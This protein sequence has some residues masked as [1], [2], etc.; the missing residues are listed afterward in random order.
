MPARLR[1]RRA[2]GGD[3]GDRPWQRPVL[4]FHLEEGGAAVLAVDVQGGDQWLTTDDRIRGHG[5]IRCPLGLSMPCRWSGHD[6]SSLSS[7]HCTAH[8]TVA[9]S[10]AWAASFWRRPSASATTG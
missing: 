5:R 2:M 1:P 4:G 7:S 3:R 8:R 6:P 10:P 9:S